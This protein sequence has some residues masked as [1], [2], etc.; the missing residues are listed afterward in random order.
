MLMF[1]L[2]IYTIFVVEKG[3]CEGLYLVRVHTDKNQDNRDQ[4]DNKGNPMGSY[5]IL[6]KQT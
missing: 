5:S 6:F 4:Y 2:S 1:S 3:V